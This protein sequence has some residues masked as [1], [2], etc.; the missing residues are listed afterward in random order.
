M[1]SWDNGSGKDLASVI[2]VEGVCC[3]E[4]EVIL[5]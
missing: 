2:A 3:N 1:Q 4:G 5:R